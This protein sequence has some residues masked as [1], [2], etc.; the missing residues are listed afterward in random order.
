MEKTTPWRKQQ[1]C[2][3]KW[4]NCV[5]RTQCE[6]DAWSAS[7]WLASWLS[8]STA[9]WKPEYNHPHQSAGWLGLVFGVCGLLVSCGRV[10]P[11]ILKRGKGHHRIV[12][13]CNHDTLAVG[14][15]GADRCQSSNGEWCLTTLAMC[16]LASMVRGGPAT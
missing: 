13:G 12:Y 7:P 8:E 4:Q 1:F 6:V 14:V 3:P 11:P 2:P 9:S 16:H 15:W 5:N 10:T